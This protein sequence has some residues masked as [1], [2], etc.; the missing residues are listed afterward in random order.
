M[1]N[2]DE[3]EMDRGP[4]MVMI[5]Y[6]IDPSKLEQ[7]AEALHHVRRLRRRDGAFMWEMFTDFEEEG[8]V[9]EC[10]MIESWLEHLRQHERETA[11]DRHIY[12]KAH[13]FHIGDRSPRVTHYIGGHM[14]E[15][16][17]FW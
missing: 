5:E 16:Q 6:R 2:R 17:Y 9:V 11:A 4:V 10:F 3:K 8:R 1:N 15:G 14:R 7:F 13:A 12:K